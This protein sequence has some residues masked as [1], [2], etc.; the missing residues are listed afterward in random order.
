MTIRN[1]INNKNNNAHI[2]FRARVKDILSWN[3]NKNIGETSHRNNNNLVKRHLEIN[4]NFNVQD[5]KI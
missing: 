5:N 3:C 1:L 2:E 4:Y